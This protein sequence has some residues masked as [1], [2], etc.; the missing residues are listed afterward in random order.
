M[1]G[2]SNGGCYFLVN[3]Y[4]FLTIPPNKT[5]KNHPQ[6]GLIKKQIIPTIGGIF[7]SGEK[8]HTILPCK[9]LT[10]SFAST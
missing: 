3:N 4:K 9:V 2:I 10:D 5:G 1:P 8:T 6:I 7:P